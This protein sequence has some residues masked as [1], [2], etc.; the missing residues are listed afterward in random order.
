[1]RRITLDANVLASGF[2]SRTSASAR[3]LS[4]CR[5]GIFQIIVS[6]HVV[7]EVA[8]TFTD[9]YFVERL[10]REEA[11]EASVVPVCLHSQPR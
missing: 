8:R 9:R 2:A 10:N 3:L 4:A 7:Q 6:D 1:L 5:A 11:A